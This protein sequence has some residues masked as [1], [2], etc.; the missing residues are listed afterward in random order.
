[1]AL[2]VGNLKT[3][4]WLYANG[5]R[6]ITEASI[7][8]AFSVDVVNWLIKNGF[9]GCTF[10]RVFARAVREGHLEGVQELYGRL[11]RRASYMAQL[12]A[13]V[14]TNHLE[15]VQWI[16]GNLREG[17]Y[18]IEDAEDSAIF[19]ALSIG[20]YEVAQWLHAH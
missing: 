1:M 20:H 5:S 15:L 12:T 19:R 6:D 17:S 7:R 8:G 2:R 14:G 18:N 10:D 16:A 9:Q 13:A 3:I 4:E 11:S